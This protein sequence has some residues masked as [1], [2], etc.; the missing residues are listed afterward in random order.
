VRN[1]AW[2]YTNVNIVI[3]FQA[4]AWARG[5]DNLC[6]PDSALFSETWIYDYAALDEYAISCYWSG[7]HHEAIQACTRLLGST[8]LPT[9]QRERVAKNAQYWIEKLHCDPEPTRFYP[10]DLVPGL[11]APQSPRLLGSSLADPAPKILVA[12]LAKQKEQTLPLYLR[13]LEAFDYPKDRIA[14]Y[15]RTNKNTDRTQE[16]LADW[17][18]RNQR[19]YAAIE[20][21]CSDVEERVQDFEEHKWN[22]TRFTALGTIRQKSLEKVAEYDCDYYFTADVDNFSEAAHFAGIGG[23]QSS[24]R[25]TIASAEQ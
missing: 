19:K 3:L 7:H 8:A 2:Q 4:C 17:I 14:L 6:Q 25:C 5:I 9:D 22:A 13:C 11:H 1:L 21:D 23:A 18:E 20:F 24:N 15:I 12:I 16:N 10:K